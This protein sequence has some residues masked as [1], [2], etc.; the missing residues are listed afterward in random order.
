LNIDH[1]PRP[2]IAQI[3]PHSLGELEQMRV[4]LP[5]WLRLILEIKTVGVG[6]APRDV[7]LK[8]KV[9]FRLR[10]ESRS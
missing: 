5:N 4:R 6:R 7:R 2:E 10:D 8:E 1:I 3:V 9:A